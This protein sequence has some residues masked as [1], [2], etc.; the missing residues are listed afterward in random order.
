MKVDIKYQSVKH[1]D[2]QNFVVFKTSVDLRHTDENG[3]E[4]KEK[5]YSEF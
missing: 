2:G 5:Y 3:T 1:Q 4:S